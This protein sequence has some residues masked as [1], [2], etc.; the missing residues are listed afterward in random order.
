MKKKIKEILYRVNKVA[1]KNKEQELFPDAMGYLNTQHQQKIVD[2]VA[3][4]AINPVYDLMVVVPVYN[5]EKYVEKCVES[6]I[7]QKAEKYRY[8]VMLIDDG[9]KDSSGKIID[10]YA[11]LPNVTVIHKE[12]GGLS[13]ARNQGMRIITGQYILFVDSDDYIPDSSAFEKM[14]EVAYEKNA[15]IVAGKF[16]RFAEKDG[17]ETKTI[18]EKL[19][20]YDHMDKVS[21][22][23]DLYGFAWGKIYRAELFEN[24]CFPK[25][26]WY[27]DTII[28]WMIFVNAK[29]TVIADVMCYAYRN[30]PGGITVSGLFSARSIESTYITKDLVENIPQELRDRDDI[31]NLFL[32]QAFINIQRVR[33]TTNETKKA[34]FFV[35]CDLKH[36]FFTD[37]KLLVADYKMKEIEVALNKRNFELMKL[38]LRWL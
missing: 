6:I 22:V 9:A 13:D 2:F 14:L 35:M 10:K 31:Y 1:T 21:A 36:K 19:K 16:Y 25:G 7:A 29:K 33:N 11:E 34:V 17:V 26:Y 18:D 20:Q 37:K 30:N 38:I 5:V 27:E 8:H 12:N 3:H 24:V 28:P 4:N 32:L 15:D 23:K